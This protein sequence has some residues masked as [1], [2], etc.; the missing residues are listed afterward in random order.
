MQSDLSLPA[1]PATQDVWDKIRSDTRPILVYGMGNGADKLLSRL[2]ALGCSVS[3][4]FASDGFVRG[5]AFHGKRVLSF[6]E[7]KEIYKNFQILLAFAT[8]RPEVLSMLYQM[9]DEYTLRMPDLP[10]SGEGSFT[11]DYYNCH[12]E[13]IRKAYE[14]LSDEASK[15]LYAEI[16]HYKLSGDIRYLRKSVV[17]LEDCYCFMDP[18]YLLNAVD[19]G[20]Y[21]GDTARELFRIF[22]SVRHIYGIEPDPKN[23]KKLQAYASEAPFRL[24][25]IH[26]ALHSENGTGDFSVSGNRNATLLKGSYESKTEAVPLRTLDSIVENEQIDSI[27]YDV[28]GAEYHAILGSMKT[29][30]RCRPYLTVSLYH[31]NEDMFVLPKLLS[32]HCENYHFYLRRTPAVPAWETRLFAIPI[33]KEVQHER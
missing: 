29:I 6:T 18:K 15:K 26:A 11:A 27:K 1:Y 21:T 17:T 31:R 13:E 8:H 3:D 25:P 30:R 9:A 22:P 10:V 28:E 20:A 24:T 16:M 4:F 7:A 12:Y 19:G 2:D 33:E 14:F 23:Y 5:H 32:E